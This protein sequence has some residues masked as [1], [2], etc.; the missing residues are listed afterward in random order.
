M[1]TLSLSSDMPKEDI[2][3]H[4]RWLWATIWLL[5]IELRTSGRALSALNCWVP[6]K[7]PAASNIGVRE[8]TEGAEGVCNLIGGTST[9]QNPQSS[10]GLNHQPKSTHGGTMAPATSS[11]EWPCQTSM[12]REALGPVKAWF[13]CRGMLGWGGHSGWVGGW[14]P[15]KKQM[16]GDGM[17]FFRG[18]TRKRDNI[19]IVNKEN[20]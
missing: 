12:G 16:R 19:W 9:N 18:E 15:S 11:R 2:G 4:Y 5:G 13:Q 1:T 8:R 14:A 6:S 3:S 20:I 7:P 17:G 10:Q